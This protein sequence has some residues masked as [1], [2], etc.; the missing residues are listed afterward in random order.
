MQHF[1]VVE[2]FYNGCVILTGKKQLR[3]FEEVLRTLQSLGLLLNLQPSLLPASDSV[4][5]SQNDLP[6]SV[7]VDDSE[8]ATAEPEPMSTEEELVSIL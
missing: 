3:A 8:K 5:A 7:S 1:Q 4:A 6:V 2:A